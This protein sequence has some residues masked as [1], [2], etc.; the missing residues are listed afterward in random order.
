M[1][2]LIKT[3]IS[4]RV[5]YSRNDLLKNTKM[6]LKYCYLDTKSIKIAKS[7]RENQ[8]EKNLCLI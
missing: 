4:L 7:K 8:R 1:I 2:V 3:N 5:K 6:I